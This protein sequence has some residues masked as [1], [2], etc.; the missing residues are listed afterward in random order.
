[1]EPRLAIAVAVL[2]IRRVRVDVGRPDF[3]AN[4]ILR[5]EIVARTQPRADI[6]DVLVLGQTYPRI[7][8]NYVAMVFMMQKN[9]N[10]SASLKVQ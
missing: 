6:A 7:T 10:V 5:G 3:Q 8:E 4:T 2:R 9:L 1:M